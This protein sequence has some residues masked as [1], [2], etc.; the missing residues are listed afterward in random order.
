MPPPFFGDVESVKTAH[1]WESCENFARTRLRSSLIDLTINHNQSSGFRRF[2]MCVYLRGKSYHYRFLFK[3]KDYFGVCSGC[4]TE[5]RAKEYELEA[6]R[7]NSGITAGLFRYHSERRIFVSL[8]TWRP[9]TLFLEFP[10]NESETDGAAQLCFLFVIHRSVVRVLRLQ[11]A[12]VPA[13]FL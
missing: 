8:R 3:G 7:V 4:S 13:I 6:E 5:G 9:K 12:W 10:V 2:R 11:P 1:L